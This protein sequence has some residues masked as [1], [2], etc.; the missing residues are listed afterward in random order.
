VR[1]GTSAFSAPLTNR[2]ARVRAPVRLNA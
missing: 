1:V 2:T